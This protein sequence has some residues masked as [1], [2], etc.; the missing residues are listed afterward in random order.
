MLKERLFFSVVA[1]TLFMRKKL[2]NFIKF[3]SLYSISSHFIIY[4]LV[5][6][7]KGFFLIQIKKNSDLKLLFRTLLYNSI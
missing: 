5:T 1:T 3:M 7:N 6:E 4:Y 2:L